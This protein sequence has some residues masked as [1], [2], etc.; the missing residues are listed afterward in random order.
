MADNPLD[1]R[2]FS[3]QEVREVLKRAVESTPSKALRKM[4]GHSLAD[5]K[6]I[7]A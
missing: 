3:D 2:T 6:A 1:D 7:G 5:L 4:D